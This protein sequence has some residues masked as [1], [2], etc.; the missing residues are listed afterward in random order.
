MIRV[1]IWSGLVW[2]GLFDFVGEP[3]TM[4]YDTQLAQELEIPEQRLKDYLTNTKH[5]LSFEV[6]EGSLL[7]SLNGQR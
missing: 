4:G 7:F 1:V 5:T 6:S 3:K 2:F